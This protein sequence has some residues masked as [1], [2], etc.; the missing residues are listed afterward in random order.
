MLKSTKLLVSRMF[1]S[2]LK[3]QWKVVESYHVAVLLSS[4]ICL[5]GETERAATYCHST[6][7][8]LLPVK[9][10]NRMEWALNAATLS[11]YYVSKAG[12]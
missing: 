6:L 3:N 8:R 4:H 1:A 2:N 11:Q 5:P 9:Q 10:F 12:F 7:Q